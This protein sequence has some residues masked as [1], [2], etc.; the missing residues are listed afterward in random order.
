[1]ISDSKI[2]K[3]LEKWAKKRNL[4]KKNIKWTD[5]F[6]KWQKFIVRVESKIKCSSPFGAVNTGSSNHLI[7]INRKKHGNNIKEIENTILHELN[8][9][10]FPNLSEARIRKITNKVIPI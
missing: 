4:T 5:N 2:Q 7:F 6:R 1:M 8:H 9:I 3:L 10:K